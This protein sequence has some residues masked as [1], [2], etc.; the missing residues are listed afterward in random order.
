MRYLKFWG[1]LPLTQERYADKTAMMWPFH[2]EMYRDALIS[3]L[4]EERGSCCS[5]L[6]QRWSPTSQRKSDLADLSKF[7][8]SLSLRSI[9]SKPDIF[10]GGQTLK[11]LGIQFTSNFQAKFSMSLFENWLSLSAIP[12]LMQR[13]DDRFDFFFLIQTYLWNWDKYNFLSEWLTTSWS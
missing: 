8:K 1:C 10:G 4:F 13:K 5:L 11:C 12:W 7:F 3:V 9:R 6:S 2:N